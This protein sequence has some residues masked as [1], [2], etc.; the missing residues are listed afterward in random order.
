M[1]ECEVIHPILKQDVDTFV[2]HHPRLWCD[3]LLY[4]R[5]LRCH[6]EFPL[7]VL[8]LLAR[9]LC[10]A[11]DVPRDCIRELRRDDYPEHKLIFFTNY[12]TIQVYCC[13][14]ASE[15]ADLESLVSTDFRFRYTHK[16]H[17][18]DGLTYDQWTQNL[19][20]RTSKSI[21][22]ECIFPEGIDME[23]L[24][25]RDANAHIRTKQATSKSKA[26][27]AKL[28]QK[29]KDHPPP[30]PDNVQEPPSSDRPNG[31]TYRTG[32]LLGRG[33]FAICY[34]GEQ[35]GTNRKY[36]LKIVKSHMPQKKMEQK[37]NHVSYPIFI[38]RLIPC[39]VSNRAA[40]PL[41]DETRKHCPVSQ[42]FL[43]REVHVHCARALPK[44]IFDGHGQEEEIYH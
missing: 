32:R 23:A 30:P 44:W 41:E 24:S 4:V 2:R 16:D 7:D 28:T 1:K 35:V 40:N 3:E 15:K 29:E 42:S 21:A 20:Y 22:W 43:L 13:H 14:N 36:A 18:L 17:K 11:L 38:Q 10:Q 34:E 8:E 6:F 31:T 26:P 19:F 9:I 12:R 27:P 37:V 39:L 33:G 25:P 5:T